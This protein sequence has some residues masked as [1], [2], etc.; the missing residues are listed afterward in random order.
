MLLRCCLIYIAIVI[1]RHVLNFVYLCARLGQGYV[2][3][4]YSQ[5][6]FHFVYFLEENLLLVLD[7]NVDEECE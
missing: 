4:F 2:I 1:L 5:S 3:I 6:H 7:D